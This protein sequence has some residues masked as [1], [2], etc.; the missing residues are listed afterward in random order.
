MRVLTRADLR[1]VALGMVQ[2]ARR[3][4]VPAQ[5]R[6]SVL[7]HA[8][9]VS[10]QLL[11]EPIPA[12]QG[13]AAVLLMF[14]LSADGG[15]GAVAVADAERDEQVH[16]LREDLA[17]MEREGEAALAELR[18]AHEEA[19]SL[20]EEL[21]SSNEEPQTYKEELQSMNEELVSVNAQIEEKIDELERALGD[22]RNLMD[23]TQVPT[24]FLDRDLRIRRC[25]EP[26]RRLFHLFD[27][28]VGRALRDIAGRVDAPT[29]L[30]DVA[31]VR[32][33]QQPTESEVAD[34]DGRRYLRRLAPYR[35]RD[36]RVDGVVITYLDI[37]TLLR[38]A[39]DAR[40][41][42]AVLDS[43]NDAVLVYEFE[44]RIRSWNRG[45]CAIYGYD[46]DAAKQLSIEALE[47]KAERG[48]ALAIAAQARQSASVGPRRACRLTREGRALDVPVSVSVLKDEAGQPIAVLSTERDLSETLRLEPEV[49]FRAM[50]DLV[51]ALLRIDDACG[52]A[53]YMNEAWLVLTGLQSSA[54]LLGTGWHS[55][56]H[57]DDLPVLVEREQR[58]RVGQCRLE[59]DL[60]LRD[61]D[62]E[63][64]WTRTTE[65]ARFDAQGSLRGYVS[66]TVDIQD[67][68]LAEQALA[69]E[70][71]RKDEL[72]AMLGH[73]LRNPLAPIGD[74]VALIEGGGQRD[75]KLR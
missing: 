35:L 7:R 57:P 17:A 63:Y 2:Q 34:A 23:A 42:A 39:A 68:K 26:T 29:L 75:P 73:E 31:A 46:E 14:D 33:G 10:L 54:P 66:L 19:M 43:S 47:P 37:T 21:R 69:Q 24:L 50:A 64:R 65:A 27:A 41:L 44:G 3:T 72:L 5:A 9:H 15:G 22:V 38:A 6:P 67:R 30:A 36:D 51:P 12:G 49:R 61:H 58:S 28:D 71:A 40:R 8:Q 20:N 59:C 18:V 52:R 1:R 53:E 55:F 25:T 74:A 45:A 32:D 62:D 56:V 48:A 16:R 60:R 70:A 4:G 11:A 13:E